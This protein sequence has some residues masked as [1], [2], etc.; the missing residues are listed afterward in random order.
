MSTRPETKESLKKLF[1]AEWNLPRAAQNAN[2][3]SKEMKI[4]FNEFCALNPPSYV[5]ENQ[6]SHEPL[7]KVDSDI[8]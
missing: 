2:L 8:L 7:R 1:H 5:P 6:V 3:T 4:I